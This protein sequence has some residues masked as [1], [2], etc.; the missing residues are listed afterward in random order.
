MD[1]KDSNTQSNIPV[2]SML[3]G[4]EKGRKAKVKIEI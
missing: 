4:E 3:K 2:I 1:L